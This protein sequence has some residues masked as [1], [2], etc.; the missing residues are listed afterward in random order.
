MKTHASCL[1]VLILL[2]GCSENNRRSETGQAPGTG[3]TPS[4]GQSS[5]THPEKVPDNN[6]KDERAIGNGPRPANDKSDNPQ[7]RED[8]AVRGTGDPLKGEVGGAGT[9]SPTQAIQGDPG[10]RP[11]QKNP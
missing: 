6:P 9:A 3:G 7:L 5:S 11:P 8:R 10:H 2:V 4:A 1:L